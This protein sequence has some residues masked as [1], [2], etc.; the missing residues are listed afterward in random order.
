MPGFDLSRHIEP[1]GAFAD[2]ASGWLIGSG[3]RAM[4]ARGHA[5]L[6]QGMIGGMELHKVVASTGCVDDPQ[7]G[8]IFIGKS[9]Q[10]DRFSGTKIR[11]ESG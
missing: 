7:A 8:R 10:P 9:A 2:L 11:T 4:Q 6:H 1:C 3:R 5:F